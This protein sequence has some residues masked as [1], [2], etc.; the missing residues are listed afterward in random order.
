MATT[1]SSRRTSLTVAADPTLTQHAAEEEARIERYGA[2]DVEDPP[3]VSEKTG[4]HNAATKDVNMVDWDGPDD[5]SNPQN[6][7]L[8]RKWSMVA[9]CILIT[10]NWLVILN[11]IGVS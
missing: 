10:I 11:R 3:P 6:W 9:L 1:T 7:S 4:F 5:P 2:D 8:R